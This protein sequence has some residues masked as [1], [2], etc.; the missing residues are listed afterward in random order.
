MRPP[1]AATAA[2]RFPS[3][4]WDPD[5]A[6]V[7]LVIPDPERRFLACGCWGGA[8][9]TLRLAESP[10]LLGRDSAWDSRAEWAEKAGWADDRLDAWLRWA[11]GGD[12]RAVRGREPCEE[13]REEPEGLRGGGAPGRPAAGTR[14]G[15]WFRGPLRAEPWEEGTWVASSRCGSG[16]SS[17][18]S[19]ESVSL[20]LRAG[21]LTPRLEPLLADF[22]LRCGGEWGGGQMLDG[23]GIGI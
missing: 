15:S 16:A 20:G 11:A 21:G 2:T 10:E 12:A 1:P 8:A 6:V 17:P 22:D 3:S 5:P 14:R 13:G 23:G 19:D 7:L 4:G 9:S 18:G